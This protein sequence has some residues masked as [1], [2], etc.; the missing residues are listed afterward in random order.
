MKKLLVVL[1]LTLMT[2]L[3]LS[4]CEKEDAFVAGE[5]DIIINAGTE[6]ELEGVL[7]L[8]EGKGPFPAVV[9]VH[10][11]GT[12]NKD[13]NIGGTQFFYKN[14]AELLTEQ[15]IAGIR[16]DKRTFTY[17]ELMQDVDYTLKEEGVDDALSAVALAK[18]AK[19]IDPDLIFVV[20]HSQGGFLVPKIYEEDKENTIAGFISLA[21]TARPL[22]EHLKW[23]TEWKLL[24]NPDISEADENMYMSTLDLCEDIENLTEA[25]RGK[26]QI[27]LDRYP[28]YWLYLADYDPAE[29]AK[30]M[31]KPVLFLQGGNDLIVQPDNL[32]LWKSA[33]QNNPK[34]AYKLYSG[35]THEFGFYYP[36]LEVDEEVVVDIA[37]F[38]K[39]QYY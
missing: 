1:G 29:S 38:I 28:S 26:D 9:I 31:D 19:K 10:G 35:L 13:G 5:N 34:M 30:N 7:T 12:Q 22:V 17:P 37:N 2:V 25:N 16:Y 39:S 15:G 24:N 4:G 27:L 21:G 14:L 36:H 18:T 8:P 33:T 11:A 23:I 32:D 6:W 20:G 3:A